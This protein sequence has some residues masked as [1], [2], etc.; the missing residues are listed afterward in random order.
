MFEIN[1]DAPT[2]GNH[3]LTFS[4][5]FPQMVLICTIVQ[6]PLPGTLMP[7]IVTESIGIFQISEKSQELW[8]RGAPEP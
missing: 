4:T 7:L 6:V 3:E 8:R 1:H 2:S 5:H